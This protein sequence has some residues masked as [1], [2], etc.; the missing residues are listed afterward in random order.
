MA[1]LFLLDVGNKWRL[2]S[3]VI[4]T[5]FS[6]VLSAAVVWTVLIPDLIGKSE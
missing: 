2:S 1:A 4:S 3:R 5:E 6:M